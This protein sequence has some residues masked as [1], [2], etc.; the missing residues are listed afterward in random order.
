VLVSPDATTLDVVE[1]CLLAQRLELDDRGLHPPQR[2][3]RPG[4]DDQRQPVVVGPPDGEA[5]ERVALVVDVAFDERLLQPVGQDHHP[6]VLAELPPDLVPLGVGQHRDVR[7]GQEPVARHPA[8]VE[9]L[10][11]VPQAHGYRDGAPIGQQLGEPHQERR[12]ARADA[13]DD[14][15]GSPGV[16][17]MQVL[18]DRLAQLVPADDLTDDARR[19]H[20]LSR[21]FPGAPHVGPVDQRQPVE[22]EHRGREGDREDRHQ[23]PGEGV[24][25]EARVAA[26]RLEVERHAVGVAAD[27]H[28]EGSD[29]PQDED[30]RGQ[31]GRDPGGRHQRRAVTPGAGPLHTS[32]APAGA[33]LPPPLGD[34]LVQASPQAP[35]A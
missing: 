7:V 24:A 34:R 15:V 22:Q 21:P 5:D 12:L 11:G 8:E 33:A 25:G 27:H 3:V 18:D 14:H 2:I 32:A 16:P 29:H 10:L 31:G 23:G 19:L 30:D 20:D 9:L 6:V 13:A 35:Q 4:R 1:R 26:R 28:H 17:V